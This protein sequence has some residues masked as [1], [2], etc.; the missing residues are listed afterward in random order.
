MQQL[1]YLAL[2]ARPK[3]LPAA[4]VPLAVGTGVASECASLDWPS[5]ALGTLTLILLQVLSNFANDLGDAS[6][7]A[8]TAQRTGPVR[9]VQ[10]GHVSVPVMKRAIAATAALALIGGAW[11]GAREGVWVVGVG[12]IGLSAALGYTLGRRPLAYRG[13]GDATVFLLLGPVAVAGATALSAPALAGRGAF[14]GIAVGALAAAL[15]MVNNIRD[16]AG[17]AEAGKRTLVVRLGRR[18]GE[19][20]YVGWLALAYAVVG[21]GALTGV[22]PSTSAAVF[23]LLPFTGYLIRHLLRGEGSTLNGVLELTALHLLLF[24]GLLS[25][26]LFFA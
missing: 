17:D 4:L 1:T 18:W 3:T 6:K 12:L 8:D 9:M 7:G 10:A 2:A 21:T 5:I 13:L 20:G 11:L 14:A 24:G 23:S 26:G 15:L 19:I 25:A 16:A 22:F